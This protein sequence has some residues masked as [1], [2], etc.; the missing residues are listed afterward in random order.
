MGHYLVRQYN[1]IQADDTP[2]KHWPPCIV[3]SERLQT[4]L[5]QYCMQQGHAL[6]VLTF[7]CALRRSVGGSPRVGWGY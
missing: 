6:L 3:V 4:N 1:A 2:L 5:Y 7:G